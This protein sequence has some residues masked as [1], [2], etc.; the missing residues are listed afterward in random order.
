MPHTGRGKFLSLDGRYHG[1]SL[2]GL[3][4]GAGS[5]EKLPNLLR[6]CDH[7]KPPLDARALERIERRLKK[8]DLAAFVM[9]PISMNLGVLVPQ[10][11]FLPELQRLCRRYGTLL[12]L[13]V[14]VAPAQRRHR[15]PHA[16]LPHSE[17]EAAAARRGEHVGILPH[18]PRG[19]ALRRRRGNSR[20]GT[21][22][23]QRLAPEELGRAYGPHDPNAPSAADA[24][25]RAAASPR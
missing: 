9:E 15:H 8:R 25:L 24:V 20:C 12:V 19:D 2:A 22:D 14:R 10:P 7:V 5:R 16:A 1:N 17:R 23:R 18:P 11:G 3:G 6:G 21:R 13:D 4:I